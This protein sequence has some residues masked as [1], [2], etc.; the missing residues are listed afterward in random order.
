MYI[1][2][3]EG[4]GGGRERGEGGR[5]EG[6]NWLDSSVFSN[7]RGLCVYTVSLSGAGGGEREREARQGMQEECVNS[8]CP[9]KQSVYIMCVFVCVC[10][11]VCV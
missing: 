11:C 6:G 5:R 1:Q 2:R 10:V 3:R 7:A 8:P 4:E 9:T